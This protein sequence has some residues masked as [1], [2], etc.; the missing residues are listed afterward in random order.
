MTT[1]ARVLQ[2]VAF[3]AAIAGLP[4]LWAA[5]ANAVP[6]SNGLDVSC[7]VEAGTGVVCTIGG[8]PRVHGDYVVDAV[9]FNFNGT[10]QQERDFKCING[11]TARAVDDIA[12]P[13]GG[14]TS[15]A[16]Q[17]CRK[18]T[19]EGDWCGPWADYKFTVPG[20][21]APKAKPAPANP[22]KCSP[23]RVLDGDHCVAAPAEHPGPA[24]APTPDVTN[25][26]QA[27]FGDP[28][29]ST[30][31]FNVTNTSNL[32]ATCNY[33]A[34]ANSLNPLVAKTTTRQFNVPANGTH[35]ETFN[36]APTFTTYSVELSCKDASG[37]QKAELGHVSTSVTW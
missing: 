8:C 23:G 14:S 36:G 10:G 11:Q 37:K 7:N 6:L 31:A 25:A 13:P 1:R 17:G 18:K 22:I 27:S 35:T 12:P 24:A 9:H 4:T 33:T 21:A 5:P 20:D 19:V 34:K 32:T 28:K 29:L 30:L 26:I 2:R 3:S 15:I 16:V